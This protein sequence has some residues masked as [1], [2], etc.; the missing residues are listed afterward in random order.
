MATHGNNK[1]TNGNL[2]TQLHAN[3]MLGPRIITTPIFYWKPTI[4]VVL[5]D[6]SVIDSMQVTITWNEY[7]FSYLWNDL[8]FLLVDMDVEVSLFWSFML[9]FF[10][11]DL[12]EPKN[13]S[14]LFKSLFS[15]LCWS[16]KTEHFRAWSP[17]LPLRWTFADWISL[18]PCS[19][20]I[21]SLDTSEYS[22]TF[23]VLDFDTSF[24]DWVM[25]F[26]DGSMTS[27]SVKYQASLDVY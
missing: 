27:P 12:E 19:D 4:G 1:W 2:L 5:P 23:E 24:R 9:I 10:P 16:H 22:S 7:K 20:S 15:K 25:P 17:K 18:S 26:K 21:T 11:L 14:T 8:R 3:P 13:G 6:Y